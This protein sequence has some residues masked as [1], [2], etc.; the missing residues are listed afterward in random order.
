MSGKRKSGWI[1]D[2]QWAD[3]LRRTAKGKTRSP[4]DPAEVK[5]RQQSDEQVKKRRWS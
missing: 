2:E 3:L 4:F 5:Q 1:S